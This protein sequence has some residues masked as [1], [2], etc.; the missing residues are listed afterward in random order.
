MPSGLLIRLRPVGPWRIGPVSGDRDRVDRIYH[1]DSLFAAV[2]SAMARLG[3][4]EAWLG[5]TARAETS[6]V[7]FSSCFPF[8]GD[9]LLVTPPLSL[10][11]PPPSAKVR[12]KGA[13]FVPLEVVESLVAGRAIQEDGW[14]I[15]TASQCLLPS[16][17][18]AGSGPFR[19]SVRSSAAVD[20]EGN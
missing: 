10:W 12:W 4:L 3:E 11:P 18:P 5:A 7:R 14:T 20:R 1:S 8:H 19:I 17:T 9:K 6:A 15:D 2:T 16:S 13:Q